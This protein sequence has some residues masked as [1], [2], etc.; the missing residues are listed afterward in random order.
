M[1]SHFLTKQPSISKYGYRFFMVRRLAVLIPI[2]F[3]LAS[4]AHYTPYTIKTQTS[5]IQ[6][7]PT[8]VVFNKP[9]Y[10][11]PEMSIYKDI[12]SKSYYVV[13]AFFGVVPLSGDLAEAISLERSDG[14]HMILIG[15]VSNTFDM[16]K[17][18][19]NAISNTGDSHA[20]IKYYPITQAA[21]RPLTEALD[22]ASITISIVDGVR[23]SQSSYEMLIALQ[24]KGA[25]NIKSIKSMLS[26]N[27]GVIFELTYPIRT[28]TDSSILQK[29]IS[30]Q[31]NLR[32]IDVTSLTK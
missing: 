31:V 29:Q 27:S 8:P 32:N 30:T 20:K 22:P 3:V 11:S 25:D 2:G 24:V 12:D 6:P 4:C 5:S 13:P 10:S 1:K 28:A 17:D 21:I 9:A 7:T 16:L 15:V 26:M 23:S 19:E 14:R 18:G